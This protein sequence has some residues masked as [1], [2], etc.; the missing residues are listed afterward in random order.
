VKKQLADT[1][2]KIQAQKELA[3]MDT[4]AA[5]HMHHIP[6]GDALM[7]PPTQAPGKAPNG[8]AFAQV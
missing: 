6:S 3:A 4:H 7:K 8:K 2:M 5:I 1:A